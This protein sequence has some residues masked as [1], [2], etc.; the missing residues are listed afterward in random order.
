MT[1][2]G[3][4][5]EL[6]DWAWKRSG[7]SEEEREGFSNDLVEDQ[8]RKLSG[9]KSQHANIHFT[10]AGIVVDL[11]DDNGEALK[12]LT[13]PFPFFTDDGL[14]GFFN[15]CIKTRPVLC[16]MRASHVLSPLID[17]V[18]LGVQHDPL[19]VRFLLFIS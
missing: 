15:L 7:L 3:T 17:E 4:L 9:L 2:I 10:D 8:L 5:D 19:K 11:I 18:R 16:A 6:R 14:L 13:L 1:R 12:S